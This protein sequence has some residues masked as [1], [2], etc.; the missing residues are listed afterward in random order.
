K[1]AFYDLV[2]KYKWE[3]WTKLGD[4]STTEAME[5]YVRVFIDSLNN[6]QLTDEDMDVFEPLVPFKKYLPDQILNNIALKPAFYDLVGKYKWEAWTKLGD[7]STTE[8][9]EGYVRVFIDSLNNM[10]LTDEDMDV[11]EPLVPF[12]KEETMSAEENFAAAVKVIRCLPK[13]GHYKPSDELRLQ[14][15]AYF[16][17]ATEGP[18]Q[19][20]KPAFYDLVGKY[21]WEAWTKLGDMSTTEAM[22][23]YVRVFIDS[24]N[25]M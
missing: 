7:M 4:M 1:P 15:Y 14:F 25:N 16:K 6:M 20:K 9:M 5:G 3:A 22:E 18:N 19:T 11:F 13:S 10:R 21:K 12:K 17:Q 24:L 8:A 23:G 2:G